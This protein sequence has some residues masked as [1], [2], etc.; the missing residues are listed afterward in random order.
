MVYYSLPA[1]LWYFLDYISLFYFWLMIYITYIIGIYEK[2][3][4]YYKMGKFSDHV[5][6]LRLFCM[7]SAWCMK[8]KTEKWTAYF[9]YHTKNQLLDRDFKIPAVKGRIDSS[10]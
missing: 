4:S 8:Q 7:N 9:V 6:I 1:A 10:N 3:K 2:K 5:K